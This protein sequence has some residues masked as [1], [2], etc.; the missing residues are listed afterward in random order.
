[1]ANSKNVSIPAAALPAAAQGFYC[2]HTSVPSSNVMATSE[3]NATDNASVRLVIP[4]I[5]TQGRDVDIVGC[6]ATDTVVVTF[7]PDLHQNV[8]HEFQVLFN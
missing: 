3:Y 4:T 7:S 2:L 5:E 8:P 1:M 6:E